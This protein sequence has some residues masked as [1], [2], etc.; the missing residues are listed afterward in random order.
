MATALAPLLCGA[1]TSLT[2]ERAISLAKENNRSIQAATFQGEYAQYTR[3]STHSLFFPSFTL[4]GNAIYSSAEGSYSSGVGKLPVLDANGMPNGLSAF[5]PG[6]DLALEMGFVYNA[7]IK[8]EQPLYQ[9]GKIA[10]GYKISKLGESIGRQNIRLT[11]AQVIVETAKAYASAVKA[12]ELEK[13]ASS[14]YALL[15]GLLSNVEKAYKAGVKP[16]S[17]VLKVRMKLSESELNLRRC[18]NA[19]R[20]ANMN[21]C[22]YIG[23]PLTEPIE[24]SD[25]L[26][27]VPQVTGG[28]ISA[29]PEYGILQD[30]SQIAFQQIRAARSDL[31][32]K[33]GIMGQYGYLNGIKLNDQKMMHSWNVLAG[34][35]ISIPLFDSMHS[36]NKLKAAKAQYAQVQAEKENST[37]LLSLEMTRSMNE[38]D[39]AALECSLAESTVRSAEENLRAS[40]LQYEKG[41]EILT[42]YLEAQT[43]WLQSRQSLI[44]ANV[45]RYI[46]YLEFSKASGSIN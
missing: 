35:Q 42:D 6:I 28:D 34:L 40:R 37:E 15:E 12:K 16:Q 38:L 31:L 29:R 22:H 26:P 30:K 1:Q 23:K 39:E 33:I 45:N 19:I 27:L 21:L 14:H 18:Q 41:T 36:A 7:G 20:L 13:V 24:I 17:D 4:S 46:C 8:V 44:E 2:L 9:G 3:K 43:L 25:E 32:P 11:E 10:A 5:F